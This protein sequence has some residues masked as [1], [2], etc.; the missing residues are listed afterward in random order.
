MF[1]KIRYKRFEVC[2][3]DTDSYS[4]NIQFLFYF[5]DDDSA[6]KSKKKKSSTSSLESVKNL[7]NGKLKNFSSKVKKQ[8]DKCFNS[9]TLTKNLV[10]EE[11]TTEE[12]FEKT[13]K[14]S[15]KKSQ[16]GKEPGAILRQGIKFANE[17]EFD[18][19]MTPN[20][21]QI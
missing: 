6:K 14:S 8:I 13:P 4:R 5:Q 16:I 12:S 9:P 1:F 17:A 20:R 7:S 2:I 3:L 21:C 11:D 10:N 15:K 18:E 19:Y